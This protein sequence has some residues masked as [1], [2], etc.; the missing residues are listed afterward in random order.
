MARPVPARALRGARFSVLRFC[1]IAMVLA[2]PRAKKSKENDEPA[3]ETDT[4]A[5]NT[6]SNQSMG[7]QAYALQLCWN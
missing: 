6:Q 2:Q 5:E 1:L 4:A 3:V 7:T